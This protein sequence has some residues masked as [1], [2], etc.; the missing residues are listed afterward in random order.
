MRDPSPASKIRELRKKLKISAQQ[1]ADKIGTTQAT[2]S[3]IETGKQV[4]TTDWL[5]KIAHAL[6]VTV[7]DLLDVADTGERVPVIGAIRMGKWVEEPIFN[8]NDIYTITIPKQTR[9]PLYE[10]KAFELDETS[11]K[12]IAKD[13]TKLSAANHIGR[14]FVVMREND[15][16]RFELSFRKLEHWP[17]G[18]FL[19]DEKSEPSQRSVR[20]DDDRVVKVWRAVAEYREYE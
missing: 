18:L 13:E 6:N 19:T 5:S 2:I 14:P 1:L 20:L 11:T 10:R 3:R 4:P 12:I 17:E 15:M 16:K 7:I 9:L 8:S